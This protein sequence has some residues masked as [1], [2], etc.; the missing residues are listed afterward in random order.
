MSHDL[1]RLWQPQLNIE[2][3]S[4]NSINT[5]LQHWMSFLPAIAKNTFIKNQFHNLKTLSF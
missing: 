4:V 3:N 1:N 2:T 5:I